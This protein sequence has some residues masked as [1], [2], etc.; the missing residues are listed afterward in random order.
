MVVGYGPNEGHG[1]E[2]EKFWNDLDR[3]VD[4]AGNGYIVYIMSVQISEPIDWR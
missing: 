1:E 3:I 4:R 2:R